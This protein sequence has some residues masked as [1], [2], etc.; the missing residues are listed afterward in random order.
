MKSMMESLKISKDRIKDLE[1]K[2]RKEEKTNKNQFEHMMRL[3]EKCKELKA[4]S[5]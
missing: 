5:Q 1:E 3:E 2:L 4:M